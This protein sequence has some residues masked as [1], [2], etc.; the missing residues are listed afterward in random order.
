[1]TRSHPAEDDVVD[2]GQP[3]P[4]DVDVHGE[5]LD[6]AVIALKD[7]AQAVGPALARQGREEADVAEV[8]AQRRHPAAEQA[9]QGAQDGAVAAEDEAEVRRAHQILV[10]DRV[11]EGRRV[12]VL[13]GLVVRHEQLDAQ[14][15][16][17]LAQR[18]HGAGD[19]GR[20]RR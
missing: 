12:G 19:R 6:D 13:G 17:Q 20:R 16:A 3:A 15:L 7:A 11:A 2:G 18:G 4:V 9:P 5:Q 14:L 1:M 10:D 8:D